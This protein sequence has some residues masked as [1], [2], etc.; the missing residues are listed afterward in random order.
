MLIYKGSSKSNASSFILLTSNIRGRYWWYGSR[1]ETFPPV[2]RYTLLPCERW[3]QRG[4]LTV[5][6]DMEVKVE[7]RCAAEFLHVGR[8]AST[9]IH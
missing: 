5:V 4:D 1:G 3:Q 7:Q 8:M 6:S 2:F 9:V